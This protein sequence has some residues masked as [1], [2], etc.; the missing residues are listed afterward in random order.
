MQTSKALWKNLQTLQ[1]TGSAKYSDAA[2]HVCLFVAIFFYF[3]IFFLKRARHASTRW[4]H[5]RR[6]P[7]DQRPSRLRECPGRHCLNCPLKMLNIWWDTHTWVRV[8]RASNPEDLYLAFGRAFGA[9]KQEYRDHRKW[10][11]ENVR[12]PGG[13]K[14]AWFVPGRVAVLLEGEAKPI[15]FKLMNLRLA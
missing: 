15:S 8:S 10:V 9:A 2:Y 12:Q 11:I 14:V 1:S 13:G 7:E 3:L 5:D 6:A 4:R